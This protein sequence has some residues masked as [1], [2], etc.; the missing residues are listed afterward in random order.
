MPKFLVEASYCTG[1]GNMTRWS[2]SVEATDLPAAQRQAYKAVLT[3]HRGASKI[4]LN[5]HTFKG[6][7]NAAY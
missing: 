5:I 4:D 3:H 2:T 6:K 1:G 7:R